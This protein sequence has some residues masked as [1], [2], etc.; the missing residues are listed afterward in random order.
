MHLFNVSATKKKKNVGAPKTHVFY[1][2]VW[3]EAGDAT[4]L[5]T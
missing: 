1:R 2:K 3:T 4:S 5:V